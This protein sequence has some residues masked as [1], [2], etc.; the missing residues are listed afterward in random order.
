MVKEGVVQLAWLTSRPVIPMVFACSRG[1]RFPSWDPFLLPFPFGRGVF[2]FGS[3]VCFAQS[4]SPAD[5]QARMQLAMENKER[6][7]LARLEEHGVS[8]V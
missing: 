7:A 1:H 5:F 8:A 6:R 3:P 4:E 2:S